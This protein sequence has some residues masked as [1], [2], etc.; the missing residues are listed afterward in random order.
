MSQ[1]ERCYC[2]FHQP[3]LLERFP[4][5]HRHGMAYRRPLVVARRNDAELLCDAL[6]PGPHQWPD[7]EPVEE[8]NHAPPPDPLP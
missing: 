3:H 4:V 1:I 5:Q 7:G 8:G 2:I 6:H